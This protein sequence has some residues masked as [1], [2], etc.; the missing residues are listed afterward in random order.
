MKTQED[1]AAAAPMCKT[2]FPSAGTSSGLPLL[3]ETYPAA[4]CCDLLLPSLSEALTT[5]YNKHT[6]QNLEFIIMLN[7][8][9]GQLHTGPTY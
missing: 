3:I 7:R 6:I 9:P 2:T 5:V 8:L 1:T 4:D